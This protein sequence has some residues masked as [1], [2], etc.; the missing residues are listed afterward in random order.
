MHLGVVELLMPVNT[1]AQKLALA[2]FAYESSVGE[3]PGISHD[4]RCELPRK[5]NVKG[6]G[7]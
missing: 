2:A 5:L 7:S 4:M 1:F 6:H 3:V